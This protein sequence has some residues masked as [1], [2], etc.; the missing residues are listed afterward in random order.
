MCVFFLFCFVCL[1]LLLF[2]NKQHYTDYPCNFGNTLDSSLH[3][4]I[5]CGINNL[6][7]QRKLSSQTNLNLEKAVTVAL[8]LE[9]ASKDLG[10]LK[11]RNR[12]NRS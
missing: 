12:A 11:R 5:V 7:I 4:R 10:D 8:A 3:N 2:A 9:A 1:F 6:P